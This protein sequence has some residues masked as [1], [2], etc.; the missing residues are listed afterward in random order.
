MR[1]NDLVVVVVFSLL[2]LRH[3]GPA[4]A[5]KHTTNPYHV[6]ARDF[7][8]MACEAVPTTVWKFPGGS[9]R[10]SQIASAVCLKDWFVVAGR[11]GGGRYITHMRRCVSTR[12]SHT[13]NCEQTVALV[14]IYT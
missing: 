14:Y 10:T 13:T 5:R 12:S 3:G 2:V 11:G 6:M 9:Q 7:Y 1:R 4:D 8:Q